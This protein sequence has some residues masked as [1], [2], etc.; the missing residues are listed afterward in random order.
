MYGGRGIGMA[1]GDA[2]MRIR[3]NAA[4]LGLLDSLDRPT[5][6]LNA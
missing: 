3:P 6:G 4:E 5:A 2:E 1:C